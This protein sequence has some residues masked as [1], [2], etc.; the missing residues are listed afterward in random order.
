MKM[1]SLFLIPVCLAAFS[2]CLYGQHYYYSPNS[3]HNPVL[4]QKN[5]ATLG[6]GLG[7]GADFSALELHGVFSPVPYGALMLNG[8]MGGAQGV[9]NM[10][11]PGASLRFLELGVGAYYPLERG[12]ASVFAGAGQGNMYNYYGEENFSSFT[13]RR[14]FLQPSLMYQDKYF[15]CGVALRLTRITYP[16]GESSFD[17]SEYELTAIKKIEDDSPFFLPE[18]GLTGGFVLSPCVI[19]V[20]LTSVFPDTPGLN[21]SRFNMSLML[22][23]ELSKFR[24]KQKS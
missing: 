8:Y 24:K 15:R 17:I 19:A 18:L 7:W 14:Y 16:Q 3:I 10:E 5:D 20:N 21:F 1:R 12:Y 9:R 13:M 4:T 2:V 11:E 6:L 22:T 23:F